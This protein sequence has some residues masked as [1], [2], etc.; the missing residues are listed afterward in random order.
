M[1]GMKAT[2]Y[3]RGNE[4]VHVLKYKPG[5]ALVLPTPHIVTPTLMTSVASRKMQPVTH[6]GTSMSSEKVR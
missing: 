2:L 5:V 6:L 4:M 3:R 1:H